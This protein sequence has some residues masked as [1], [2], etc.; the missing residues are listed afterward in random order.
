MNEL[1]P[2]G[3]DAVKVPLLPPE[4]AGR[5]LA[6]ARPRGAAGYGPCAFPVY[7]AGGR[8]ADRV[9]GCGGRR[10]RRRADRETRP[11]RSCPGRFPRAWYR[12]PGRARRGARPERRARAD[13]AQLVTFA[14]AP[15]AGLALARRAIRCA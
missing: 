1:Q 14:A 13:R 15:R 4:A 12:A 7:A 6:P 3:P 11:I 9:L 8:A 10:R 2:G 5:E